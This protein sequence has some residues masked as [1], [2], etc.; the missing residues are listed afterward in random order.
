MYILDLVIQQFG[1]D[2]KHLAVKERNNSSAV[3]A[4]FVSNCN[5]YSGRE[6]LVQKLKQFISVDI[7]GSTSCSDFRGCTLLS[8]TVLY[9]PT[10][11]VTIL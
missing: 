8:C 3:A 2:N 7:Y 11:H 6:A 4:W 10:L 5:N 1:E 9:Y